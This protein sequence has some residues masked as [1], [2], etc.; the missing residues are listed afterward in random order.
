MKIFLFTRIDYKKNRPQLEIEIN[1]EK[2]SDL[3][4][5]NY[6]IGRTLEILLA[7]RKI[8]TFIENGEEY[9]VI[10]QAK[11]ENRE[12]IKDLGSFEVKA[13]NGNFVRLENILEFKEITEAKEL[14]RFNKMRS[15]TLSAG[16]QK[17]YSLGEAIE[18]LE[19][20]SDKKLKKLY[21]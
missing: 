9:Y 1:K 5:S 18:Y 14:N 17:G 20:I 21:N 10:L 12:N 11:K 7:G 16:L 3:E 19:N 8:N 6:E 2:S 13:E 4:I 15:I